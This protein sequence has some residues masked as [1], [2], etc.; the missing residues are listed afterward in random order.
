MNAGE[1]RVAMDESERFE[2]TLELA[3]A[4]APDRGDP[5]VED[6]LVIGEPGD[7]GAGLR[8]QGAC[9]LSRLL[10]RPVGAARPPAPSAPTT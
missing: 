6:R 3:L 9:G 4:V 2:D 8:E 7:P 1:V 5:R 10:G